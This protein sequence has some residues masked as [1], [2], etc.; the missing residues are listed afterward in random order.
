MSESRELYGIMAEFDGPNELVHAAE[1]AYRAG[2]R[3]MDGYTPYPIEEL[4]EALGIHHTI[5]PA[6]VLLAG[7]AGLVGGFGL[8]SWTS[9]VAYPIN[10]GGRP[11]VS[12]PAFIPVTFETTVL[13]AALMAVFGMIALNGLPQPYHPVFNVPRFEH[14]SRDGFFLCIEAADPLFDRQ[15]TR[16]FLEGLHPRSVADVEA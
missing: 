7:V 6:L 2:Y 1:A 9:A 11:L 15:E 16:K 12:V 10:V 3:K 4:A 13:A 8:A 5:L 14:A